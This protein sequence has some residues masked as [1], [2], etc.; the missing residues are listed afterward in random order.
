M[1][2][3]FLFQFHLSE[4]GTLLVSFFTI[5]QS[6]VISW[7]ALL[8]NFHLF[9]IDLLHA[10][11]EGNRQSK[12]CA[13]LYSYSSFCNINHTH[14]HLRLSDDL[15]FLSFYMLGKNLFLALTCFSCLQGVFKLY[16]SGGFISKWSNWSNN[17][18]SDDQC[19]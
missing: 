11:T 15:N 14:V 16:K 10:L 5:V 8:I 4:K 6:V 3:L 13:T 19:F 18:L 1:G 9:S 2:R 17:R 12:M 7:K